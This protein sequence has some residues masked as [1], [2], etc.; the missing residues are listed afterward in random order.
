MAEIVAVAVTPSPPLQVTV[1][2]LS[3][4]EVTVG[5]MGGPVAPS[6]T[7]QQLAALGERRVVRGEEDANGNPD[8]DTLAAIK[9]LTDA[10]WPEWAIW[11]EVTGTSSDIPPLVP[12]S[13]YLGSTFDTATL[14]GLLAPVDAVIGLSGSE[15]TLVD[16]ASLAADPSL[17]AGTFEEGAL[18]GNLVGDSAEVLCAFT[19]ATL[20][21]LDALAAESALLG[22][23]LSDGELTGLV[24]ADS[25]L[26]DS[27]LPEGE[28]VGLLAADSATLDGGVAGG[29]L[30]GILA[31]ESST[32]T[33]T[34]STGSVSGL[35][36][37]EGS[38][39]S[40]TLSSGLLIGVMAPSDGLVS[41]TA[42]EGTLTSVALAAASV[43]V[44]SSFGAGGLTGVLAPQSALVSSSLGGGVLNSATVGATVTDFESVA[45]IG[46][47]VDGWALGTFDSE[48]GA[49]PF[50]EI[51]TTTPHTGSKHLWVNTSSYYD[52]GLEDYAGGG[53]YLQKTL[54]TST[55]GTVRAYIT[56]SGVAGGTAYWKIDTAQ[57]NIFTVNIGYVEVTA[58]VPAGTHTVSLCF[59]SVTPDAVAYVDDI[60]VPT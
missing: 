56:W 6:L 24:A 35:V 4:V 33:A 23:A 54:T 47:T 38:T 41:L 5:G 15:G 34:A 3:V 42:T 10:G 16:A 48:G 22:S 9:F 46:N 58:T 21:D 2:P 40:S 45:V 53:T 55:G 44:T 26:L 51:A 18:I 50:M 12:A 7:P 27:V 28:L 25:V 39:T 37:P 30:T 36:A 17:I 59:S 29:E 13:L 8:A 1:S 57:Q 52:E 49:A 20:S 60:S 11:W 32:L 31:A 14:S 43:T 19:E